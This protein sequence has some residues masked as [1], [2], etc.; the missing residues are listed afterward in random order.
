VAA[1]VAAAGGPNPRP[2]TEEA[3][4]ALLL[5]AQRGADPAGTAANMT[6]TSSKPR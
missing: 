4:R 6:S 3:V 1:Q 5:A 2:V